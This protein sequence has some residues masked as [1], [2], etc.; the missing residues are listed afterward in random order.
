VSGLSVAAR[1]GVVVKG[2]AVLE[3]LARCTTLLLDKTGT[4]TTGRPSVSG[5]I[6][7]GSYDP[8]EMV[9]QAASLD[10]VSAHVLASAVVGAA[11]ARGCQLVLPQQV[12]EVPGRGIRGLVDG[13]K[14]AVG[15]AGWAGVAG[16]PQW[17]KAARRRAR[18]DGALTVFVA[19]DGVPAGVLVL[20]DPVR[21]DAARTIR[22]LREGGISRIVM[23]T[24]DRPEVA[25]TVGAV[26][27]VDQV[28]AERTPA[29][30]LDAVRLEHARAPVIMVGDGINDAPALALADVGV[31]MGARG[32]GASSE[33]ADAVLTVDRLDR[34]G[35]AR[36][37][38]HHTVRIARQ[39]VIAG[40]AMSLAAM[41]GSRRRAAARR[42]GRAAAGGDRRRGH[43]QRPAGAAAPRVPRAPGRHRHRAHRPV[44][45]RA[46]GDLDRHRPA[47]RRR[48]CPR[49]PPPSRG[50]DP[51]HPGLPATRGRDRPARTSRTGRALPGYG[52]PPWQPPRHR[53]HEQSY[54]SRWPATPTPEDGTAIAE[55]RQPLPGG[56]SCW[57]ERAGT[58]L[59]SVRVAGAPGTG[60]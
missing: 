13:H 9:R 52:P 19:V 55:L 12:E 37:L 58:A 27:G 5:I 45:P 14:V 30:K 4:L 20:E 34:L 16:Q 35:E 50:D 3:R 22:A 39:S 32:S 6:T 46:P 1:R 26:I 38:A 51:R 15:K 40:M 31:A 8:D 11:T 21:P 18:L 54:L 43:P 28:L 56:L 2:G 29:D 36:T 53:H 33:A 42:V 17:V 57:A 24:G 25:D 59:G 10:Q 7:A 48:R 49:N 44:H 47:A 60:R 23:V 41:A